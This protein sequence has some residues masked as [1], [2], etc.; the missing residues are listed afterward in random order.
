[1][2]DCIQN[3]G[4]KSFESIFTEACLWPLYGT[5]LPWHWTLLNPTAR[6]TIG[7]RMHEC[8]GTGTLG[9]WY[10]LPTLTYFEVDLSSWSTRW[11]PNSWVENNHLN[12]A[13]LDWTGVFIRANA[14]GALLQHYYLEEYLFLIPHNEWLGRKGPRVRR[15]PCQQGTGW[16]QR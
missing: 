5:Y 7:R 6:W 2:E 12:K 4:C 3:L 10:S 1:M 9:Y 16:R 14:N 15:W 11:Y 13:Y 8:E